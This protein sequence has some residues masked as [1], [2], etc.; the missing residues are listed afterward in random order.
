MNTEQLQKKRESGKKWRDNNR[1]KYREY[2]RKRRQTVEGKFSV[3]KSSS[4][5]KNLEFTLTFD[6][7][8]SL[9]ESSCH[10]C[11]NNDKLVG[12][13]RKDNLIGYNVEN[14]LPCCWAC[15]RF[16]GKK[17]YNEFIARCKKISDNL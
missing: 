9:I 11:G 16:K 4:R 2:F 3:Y 10:Y 14:C 5:V 6:E 13:D 12:I 7:F 1:E 17:N 8:K 15:N